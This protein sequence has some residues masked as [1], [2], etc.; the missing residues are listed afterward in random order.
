M[1]DLASKILA[2]K[3]SVEDKAEQ[4]AVK[5]AHKPKVTTG[6]VLKYMFL[7][8]LGERIAG[9]G[10]RIGGFAYFLAQIFYSCRLIP[11]GHPVLNPANIGYFGFSDVIATAA[12]NLQIRKENTD[13]VVMFAAV[14]I[15]MVLLVAN[16]IAIAAYTVLDFGTANAQ[17]TAATTSMFAS[18]NPEKDLAL[19]YLHRVFGATAVTM[20]DES[21]GSGGASTLGSPA[22]KDALYHMLGLYSTAMMVI[23]VIIVLYYAFTVVGESAMTGQPFGKRFNSFWAPIRLVIGLGLLVPI[24]G[25]LNAA[26]YITLY[27]AKMGSGFASYAWSEFIM[28][29]G[30]GDLISKNVP[31]PNVT[32][33]IHNIVRFETCAAVASHYALWSNVSMVEETL[34]GDNGQPSGTVFRWDKSASSA[35]YAATAVGGV[36]GALVSGIGTGVPAI[37]GEIFVP[38]SANAIARSRESLLGSQEVTNAYSAMHDTYAQMVRDIQSNVSGPIRVVISLTNALDMKP[39][40]F[41]NSNQFQ[42]LRTVGSRVISDANGKVNKVVEDFEKAYTDTFEQQVKDKISSFSEKGWMGAGMYYTQIADLNG[43]LL[44]AINNAFPR[45]TGEITAIPSEAEMKAADDDSWFGEGQVEGTEYGTETMRAMAKA[46]TII[47][48]TFAT[49]ENVEMSKVR[50]HRQSFFSSFIIDLFGGE[51]LRNFRDASQTNPLA[52]LTALGAGMFQKAFDYVGW[53]IASVA[54]SGIAGIIA[55]VASLAVTMGTAGAASPIAFAAIGATVVG[56]ILKPIAGIL[57]FIATFGAAVGLF[58]YYVVPLLPFVF[59]FFA[60][61]AW[62]LEVIE[63]MVGLPLWALAH[64]RID[65]DGVGQA[66]QTGYT[67]IFGVIVRPFVILFGLIIGII[68]YSAG[69]IMVREMFNSYVSLIGAGEDSPISYAVYCVMYAVISFTLGMLCFKQCDQMSSNIMRWFGG[70]DPRYNDGQPDPAAPMQ[71][72]ALGAGYLMTQGAQH[73]SQAVQGIG[74]GVASGVGKRGEYK[75][76]AADKADKIKGLEDRQSALSKL[77]DSPERDMRMAE[78]Q[79]ELDGL[80][81]PS[82]SNWFSKNLGEG[83]S[84]GGSDKA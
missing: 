74:D 21:V 30:N 53:I 16:G 14:V 5:N 10:K 42:A 9:I 24:A 67:I 12:A 69:M 17:E 77:P 26:Q 29:V 70:S 3:K 65:G 13:Q 4:K 56:S 76:M 34:D 55:S 64:I 33:L 75:K 48:E 37:C 59:F 7:P 39:G 44:N 8:Q 43:G 28:K 73:M 45:I 22:I 50:N 72:T 66:T 81:G 57:I 62:V 49:S 63:A 36:T 52:D 46:M 32:S 38:N 15:S 41:A 51:Y 80:R 18:P 20:F 6:K 19:E 60:V 11:A 25:G 71:Q 54:L 79:T 40:E 2:R 58:L 23:A 68:L 82:G 27:A 61:T 78:I 47:P 35:A 31:R 84:G 1:K 83:K